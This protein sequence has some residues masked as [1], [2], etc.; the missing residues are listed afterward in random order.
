VIEQVEITLRYRGYIEQEMRSAERA[1]SDERVQIPA[2]VDYWCIPAMRFEAR[3]KLNRVRPTSMG[4]AGRVPGVNPAD[5]AV[6]SVVIRR[7]PE[8]LRKA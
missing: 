4:Q 5:L 6:L 2:W 3:E 1:R 8:A 7:G